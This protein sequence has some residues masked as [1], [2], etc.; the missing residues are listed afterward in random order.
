MPHTTVENGVLRDGVSLLI[1]KKPIVFPNNHLMNFVIPLSFYD[2][3][4]H[5]RAVNQIADISNDLDLL[6]TLLKAT[7]EKTAYQIIRHNT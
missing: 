7:D 4:K 6:E 3:T 1:S 5:L 2:L